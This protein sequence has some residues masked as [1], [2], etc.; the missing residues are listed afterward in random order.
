MLKACHKRCA[1]RTLKV[2]EKNG[3]IFI[4]LGQHLSAMN[5]LL[6][7]EWTT[8]FIPLQDKC[9]VSSFE[10][11]EQMFRDDT[12]E[13]LWSYFSEFATEPIGAASLAQVH[14][15]T[16]KDTGKRVAVK[17]Q[18]PPLAQWASLDLA[19]TRFTFA[20]L[21]RFFPEYDLEWLSS[22]MEV[23]LPKELDFQEEADNAL[24]TKAHFSHIPEIPLVI[25]DVVWAKKRIL[26]MA[27]E[28]G[29]RPD[30]LEYL[31]SNGI[32]RD[33]VSA[34]L[35]RIFNEMIFGEGA[36][37][38][39]DP[40]GGN[41]AIRRNDS[42]RRLGGGPNF[43]V[44]LY[45]HG[46][47]R[48]IP[49]ALRRSYAK[50]WL[51]IIDGDLDRM[52]TYSKEVAGIGDREFPIFASAITGRDFSVLSGQGG[53]GGSIL[54]PR[55]TG[56]QKTM[57]TAL[58]EGL[59]ADL[60]QLLG[61]VPRIILLILKT[62]D[63]TR[64]LDENLHTRQGPVRTF[65]ILG[66]YCARTVF[67]EQ[68]D[69]IRARGSPYWPPNAVRLFAAWLGFLRVELKLEAFE[70]WLGIKRVLGLQMPDFATPGM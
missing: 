61:R 26:V 45:D 5:Y 16:I 32:D 8:T 65:M 33:E 27:Y 53:S 2:L 35:A 47:Y 55:D 7:Q 13:E 41:I 17:V 22:E 52:R 29:H 48:D 20:S 40:H 24:R 6:P 42:R 19:L 30:D 54:T 18:H 21:K 68:V 46:L 3:G 64:S 50:M 1:D 56:E 70:C 23:S 51:A 11:I 66:R 69:E 38:H 67:Y 4:K 34:A 57:S 44:I 39:C 9:P 49:M 60:V 10:S 15:A 37:L 12:G 43:D 63:L 25:P 58:Q 31:D 62:N 14:L 59:L 36:P 28:S